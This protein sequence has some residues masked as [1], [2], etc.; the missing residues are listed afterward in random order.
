[1]AQTLFARRSAGFQPFFEILSHGLILDRSLLNQNVVVQEGRDQCRVAI[2]RF[3]S[4]ETDGFIINAFP[5]LPPAPF[6]KG[7]QVR[8][9]CVKGG[10]KIVNSPDAGVYRFDDIMLQV[11]Q[12]IFQF[13]L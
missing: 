7:C 8:R 13:L 12:E 4:I 1:M 11:V 2:F 10:I 5:I 3:E 6:E 9:V